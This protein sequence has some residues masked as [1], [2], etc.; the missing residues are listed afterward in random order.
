[1]PS[2]IPSDGKERALYQELLFSR[3][4]SEN[5]EARARR[6]SLQLVLKI[7]AL[8]KREGDLDASHRMQPM[9]ARRWLRGQDLDFAT[10]SHAAASFLRDS[11][12]RNI[13]KT[14]FRLRI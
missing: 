14:T 8:L 2:E 9:T 4:E 1:M 11:E 3:E 6:L 12:N 7:T 10:S 5:P 13:H